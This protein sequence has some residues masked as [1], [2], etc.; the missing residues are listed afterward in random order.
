MGLGEEYRW[1]VPVVT[2]GF[3]PSFMNYFGTNGVAEVEK[4]IRMLNDLPPASLMD[5]SQ[6]PLDNR[7]Q[8]YEASAMGSVDLKTTALCF[9]LEAMGLAEPERYAWTLRTFSAGVSGNNPY[10]NFV[11]VQ[12]NFDPVTWMASP[13]VNGIRY[14]YAI[15]SYNTPSAYLDAVETPDSSPFPYSSIAGR[16]FYPGDY[17]GSLTRDD[18]GGLRYLLSRYNWNVES[19]LPGTRGC[20]TNT[21]TF[22]D[23]AL[24]PGVEKITFERVHF[25]SMLGQFIPVTNRYLDTYLANS[26]P[27]RQTLER[28][29]TR[30]DI[31]FATR[32]FSISSGSPGLVERTGTSRWI[33][34]AVL[35]SYAPQDG[36]G[37]IQ[38]PLTITFNKL[39]AFRNYLGYY[40]YPGGWR[41]LSEDGAVASVFWGS[42][43]GSTNAV[44][45]YPTGFNS[46]I[47]ATV[48]LQ[49]PASIPPQHLRWRLFVPLGTQLQ[50]ESSTNLLDWSLNQV[51][52]I[53]DREITLTEAHSP[54]T[55]M[56]FYRMRLE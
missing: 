21:G 12:R 50:L 24:R 15:K 3:D 39:T 26:V 37:V 49:V 20:G 27:V 53:S 45:F 40:S 18:A 36:P 56:R 33:N 6:F 11:V 4:A 22:V 54:A 28:V 10:T 19:L 52:D 55:P 38:P 14:T 32:N 44:V 51:F 16:Q 46:P 25:D 31:L 42:F 13:Y 9:L 7:A 29:I 41:R 48:R 47:T 17:Y 43:D 23:T 2:Y 34:N 35:N 5:L 30:P 1:N 8:N